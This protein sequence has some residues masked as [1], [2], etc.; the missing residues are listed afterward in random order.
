MCSRPRVFLARERCVW[1]SGHNS[2]TKGVD[3]PSDK[4]ILSPNLIY[5]IVIFIRNLCSRRIVVVVVLL[6]PSRGRRLR[7]RVRR[8]RRRGIHLTSCGERARRRGA[9][10]AISPEIAPTTHGA[11][12]RDICRDAVGVCL[13]LATAGHTRGRRTRCGPIFYPSGTL[14]VF[15]GG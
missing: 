5:N 2:S 13:S 15:L 8:R 4:R 1:R 11:Y 7:P 3:H 12:F 14:K 10:S 6:V 9:A